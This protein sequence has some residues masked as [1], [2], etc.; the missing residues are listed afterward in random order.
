MV[1]IKK[2]TNVAISEKGVL[3]VST[4]SEGLFLCN[5]FQKRASRINIPAKSRNQPVS[6]NK[7]IVGAGETVLLATSQGAFTLNLTTKTVDQKFVYLDRKEGLQN[8]SDIYEETGV[9]WLITTKN[10]DCQ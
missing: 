8:I 2:L 10:N 3:I 1:P 6:I 9:G 4:E 5:L 7:I